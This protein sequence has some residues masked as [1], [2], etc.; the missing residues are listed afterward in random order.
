[1][2]FTILEPE[3]AG[4]LGP[5][6]VADRSVHPPRVER[7]HYEFDG[8]LGD[9]LLESFPCFIVSAALASNLSSSGLSGFVLD[10]VLVTVSSEFAELYPTR[11]LPTFHWLKITGRAGT[12]DFGLSSDH[13]LVVSAE[14]LA[15]LR[16]FQLNHAEPRAFAP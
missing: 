1:M 14:A 4:G 11:V 15:T 16:L 13:R 5:S 10:D 3:V 8:W 9:E 12:D 7:L 2:T 6:T